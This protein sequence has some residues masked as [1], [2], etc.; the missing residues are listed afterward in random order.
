[1]LKTNSLKFINFIAK[2]KN[3]KILIFGKL[4]EIKFISIQ[5]LNTMESSEINDNTLIDIIHQSDCL[6]G[7]IL[8]HGNKAPM[9]F[10]DNLNLDSVPKA[11]RVNDKPTMNI[12]KIYNAKNSLNFAYQGISD[13]E[14]VVETKV[15]SFVKSDILFGSKNVSSGSEQKESNYRCFYCE[16]LYPKG[17]IRLQ[18]LNLPVKHEVLNYFKN[19]EEVTAETVKEF[20]ERF[21]HFVIMKFHYGGKSVMSA[22]IKS[23]VVSSKEESEVLNKLKLSFECKLKKIDLK[24]DV[25]NQGD[26]R[27]VS[28]SFFME[29]C[30]NTRFELLGGDE[31]YKGNSDDLN[32][33]LD[34]LNNPKTWRMVSIDSVMS[35]YRFL[36]NKIIKK[37]NEVLKTQ[38]M[39]AKTIDQVK[40]G[41]PVSPQQM[42]PGEK[43]YMPSVRFLYRWIY[44]GAVGGALY[45]FIKLDLE[46][47][48]SFFIEKYMDVDACGVWACPKASRLH[49]ATVPI[50]NDEHFINFC[51]HWLHFFNIQKKK[52][53]CFKYIHIYCSVGESAY[54]AYS[55]DKTSMGIWTKSPEKFSPLCIK[56]KDKP[57]A[58]FYTS[59]NKIVLIY[60]TDIIVC[61]LSSELQIIEQE[62]LT[63]IDFSK[64][65]PNDVNSYVWNGNSIYMRCG[66]KCYRF[67]LESYKIESQK[68][69]PLK[70]FDQKRYNLISCSWKG[71]DFYWVNH[72]FSK[73]SVAA[74]GK[75]IAEKEFNLS[76]NT[77]L[78]LKY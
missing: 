7:F 77:V 25:G 61:Q 27:K 10:F 35:T 59:N 63:G 29:N 37:F 13:F 3:S 30:E 21:G 43:I 9:M 69:D 14:T 19:E 62:I 60:A 47:K 72:V 66:E 44:A 68:E 74:E 52:N 70:L 50:S 31:K 6:T 53:E 78:G 28:E 55:N 11:A 26:K 16:A 46:T 41:L 18:T 73:V 75:V 38:E 58:G 22:E 71:F 17:G 33:W 48:S 1:M 2:G 23:T 20:F 67:D 4:I 12:Q 42:T 8:P 40:V 51:Y 56:T 54:L 32:F 76:E 36:P 34:S 15:L 57:L 65:Q 39:L 45:S 49:E 5:N 64:C 24:T